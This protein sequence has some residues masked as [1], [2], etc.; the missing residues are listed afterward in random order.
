MES[1]RYGPISGRNNNQRVGARGKL[2][3]ADLFC[4][5][6]WQSM[7]VAIHQLSTLPKVNITREGNPCFAEY[8]SLYVRLELYKVLG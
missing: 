4:R 1:A 3:S 7:A 8:F 2:T 6:S 5:E